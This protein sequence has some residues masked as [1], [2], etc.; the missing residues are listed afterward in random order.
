M[1]FIICPI[2]DIKTNKSSTTT[3]FCTWARRVCFSPDHISF[4][5]RAFVAALWRRIIVEGE[6]EDFR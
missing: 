1:F 6:A 5:A 3:S 2:P 4:N